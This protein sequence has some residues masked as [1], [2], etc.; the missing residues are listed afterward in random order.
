MEKSAGKMRRKKE[1]PPN[2]LGIYHTQKGWLFCIWPC[3]YIYIYTVYIYITHL[4]Q[5][6]DCRPCWQISDRTLLQAQAALVIDFGRGNKKH[7]DPASISP[8]GWLYSSAPAGFA[9]S[10]ISPHWRTFGAPMGFHVPTASGRESSDAKC[11]SSQLRLFPVAQDEAESSM[12][13]LQQAED[14]QWAIRLSNDSTN[15]CIWV[16]H[17][18]L[19]VPISLINTINRYPINQ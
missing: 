12:V 9:P 15:K 17:N 16:P 2:I 1:Q 11:P 14:L 18:D 3:V 5:V 6:S 19:G 7:L 4:N 10:R 13:A 8:K